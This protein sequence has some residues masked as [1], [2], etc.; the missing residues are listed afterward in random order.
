LSDASY[1]K[2][3]LRQAWKQPNKVAAA[4]VAIL[5]KT[6]DDLPVLALKSQVIQIPPQIIQLSKN[7]PEIGAG[8]F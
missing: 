2:E 6:H 8:I 1:L 3:K 7:I 5:A 4:A